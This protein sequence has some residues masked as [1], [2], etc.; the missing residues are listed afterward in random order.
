[1]KQEFI[2]VG[3][4]TASSSSRWGGVCL[5]ACWDTTSPLLGVGLETPQRPDPSISPLGVGPWRPSKV[6]PLNFPLGCGPGDPPSP[7]R[8]APQLP[9]PLSIT[10]SI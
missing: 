1:M 5:S 10:T 3:L 2:P 8:Q 9:H 6:R 7:P 4:R